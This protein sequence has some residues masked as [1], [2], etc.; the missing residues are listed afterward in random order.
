MVM[1]HHLISTG[2]KAGSGSGG[3]RCKK[4]QGS[5][6]QVTHRS[7]GGS[8]IQQ[9]Q[10]QCSDC[11][12]TGDFIKEKDRCKKCKGKKVVEEDKTLEVYTVGG[13]GV[14]RAHKWP[15]PLLLLLLPL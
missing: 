15:E 2:G 5:G 14:G 11:G 3:Q 1:S 10:S 8:L 7:L 9:I 4:C 12:G 6:I 13:G